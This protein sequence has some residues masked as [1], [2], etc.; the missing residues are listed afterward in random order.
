MRAR[1]IMTSPVHTVAADAAVADAAGLLTAKAVTALPVV[2][3][4][5]SLVGMVS[6]GDLL[7]QRV[8]EDPTAHLWRHLADDGAP[9]PATV[10]AVMSAGAV[11]TTPDADVSDVAELMLRHDVRSVPVVVGRRVVGHHQPPGHPGA[12][13][14]SLPA[15]P[16]KDGG[17]W[18]GHSVDAR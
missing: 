17:A 5:G 18:T 16:L 8:P 13:G 11:T 6:E 3:A 4:A 2:D 10:G 15:R 9:A 14:R 1:D 7:A 12:D